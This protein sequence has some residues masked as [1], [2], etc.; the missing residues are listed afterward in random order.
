MAI[1]GISAS[2]IQDGN[3]D[4]L[5]QALLEQSGH[6]HTFVNLSALDFAPCR[7]C[8]HLCAKSNICPI[9]DDLLPY[10]EPILEADALVLGSPIHAGTVT[11]WMFSFL[12]RIWC[13]RHLKLLL[14][15]KPVLLAATGLFAQ[16]EETALQS[17]E[18]A[19]GRW[20]HN[21]DHIGSIFHATQ[22]PPCYKCGVG[23]ACRIGGLWHMVGQDEEKLRD[24]EITP[25]KFTRWEDCPQTVE[26]VAHY[27]EMLGKISGD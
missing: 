18:E 9:E 17:F 4:R 2:P 24:F 14:E 1:V 27:A 21:M 5:V 23:K 12:S 7:G 10:F 20:G 19:I 15:G 16:G 13:F 26:R 11:A 25:D 22:I 3:T 6:E 8:A